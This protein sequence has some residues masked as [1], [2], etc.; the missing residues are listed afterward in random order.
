VASPLSIVVVE[1]NDD[2]REA[3]VDALAGAGH[4]VTG[5]DCAEALPEASASARLDVLIVDRG[6]PGEDGMSLVRR[7]RA[8]APQVGV[9]MVTARGL[10]QERKEGY[11]SG[12][13]IYLTKPLSLEELLSA[14][15][16]LARRLRRTAAPAALS[17]DLGALSLA[18][19]SGKS[20]QL[21]HQEAALL[22]ALCRA[23]DHQLENWQLTDVVGRF[24]GSQ[25]KTA[26]EVTITRL[27]KKLVQAGGVSPAIRAIRGWGYR[28]C[29]PVVMQSSRT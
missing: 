13:D 18:G 27:R 21:S 26:L 6:L 4:H 1:D 22:A 16:S 9:V 14:T 11:D 10:P 20:V 5:V 3:M 19:P 25:A 7:L 2:L 23:A 15:Q 12:A 28:L 8:V 24:S 17:V 29:V